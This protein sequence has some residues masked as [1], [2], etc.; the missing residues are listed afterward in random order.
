M[1]ATGIA[2]LLFTLSVALS[3]A[4]ARSRSRRLGV[5]TTFSFVLFLAYAGALLLAI[6]HM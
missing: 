5:L 4:A 6:W 3:V 2:A 1:P